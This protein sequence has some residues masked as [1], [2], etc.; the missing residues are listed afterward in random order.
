[1]AQGLTLRIVLR[2][3]ACRDDGEACVDPP[4]EGAMMLQLNPPLPLETPKG[5]GFAH[6]L[7]DYGL[8]HDLLWVT[9][10]DENG[11]VWCYRNRDIRFQ[12]NISAGRFQVGA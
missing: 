11:Q 5:K 1:M 9:V 6:V 3:Q 12:T 2:E 8:E 10:L 4:L 7:I